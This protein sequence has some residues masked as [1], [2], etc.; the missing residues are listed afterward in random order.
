MKHLLE[1]KTERRCFKTIGGWK[2]K[3]SINDRI[4]VYQI[5][6]MGRWRK[7]HN[8]TVG[9]K[10]INCMMKKYFPLPKYSRL[11]LGFQK[12]SR[13]QRGSLKYFS[14]TLREPRL[15]FIKTTLFS[16]R[17]VRHYFHTRTSFFAS[18]FSFYALMICSYKFWCTT[19]QA[20]H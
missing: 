15:L 16:E 17:Y 7:G 20:G 8:F 14:F 9:E 1:N 2:I 10:K 18:L 4:E 6:W 13:S 12:I 11:N 19:G 5:S 3:L